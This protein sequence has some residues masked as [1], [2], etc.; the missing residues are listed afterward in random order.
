MSQ[1]NNLMTAEE[2][3]IIDS[4]LALL[5][6]TEDDW[7]AIKAFLSDRDVIVM[8][9]EVLPSAG[10]MT[11]SENAL[12]AFTTMEKCTAWI[13]KAASGIIFLIGS[14]PFEQAVDVAD[15]QQMPLYL[16]VD[17]DARFMCYQNQRLSA[18]MLVDPK[19]VAELEV[20][21]ARPNDP[22]PCGSGKKYK[23][24]CGRG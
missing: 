7:A 17:Y 13:N 14:L 22:C 11:I 15:E 21:K 23:K 5:H 10:H 18:R 16:D 1:Q 20:A 19:E 3:S 8:E 2:L 9:S 6:R 24:C 12:L 4:K